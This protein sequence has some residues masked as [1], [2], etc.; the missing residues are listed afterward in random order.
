[1]T[2]K[3]AIVKKY[4]IKGGGKEMAMMVD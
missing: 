1:M 3:K 4:E 2:P